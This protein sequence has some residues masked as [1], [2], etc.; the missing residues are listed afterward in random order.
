MFF[1]PVVELVMLAFLFVYLAQ[2]P[3]LGVLLA[4]VSILVVEFALSTAAVYRW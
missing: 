2:G 3:Y 4:A 1:V